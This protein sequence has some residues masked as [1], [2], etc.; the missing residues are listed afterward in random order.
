[1]NIKGVGGIVGFSKG[2]ILNIFFL[3]S[4]GN[5]PKL[6]LGGCGPVRTKVLSSQFCE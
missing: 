5:G 4:L 2:D 1:M 6:D 3:G